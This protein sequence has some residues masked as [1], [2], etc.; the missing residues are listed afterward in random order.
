M[1]NLNSI[2]LIGII[3]FFTLM[4]CI[5]SESHLII[6]D[7]STISQTNCEETVISKYQIN[8]DEEILIHECFING[9]VSVVNYEI[10]QQIGN[11]GIT[12]NLHKGLSILDNSIELDYFNYNYFLISNDENNSVT[13]LNNSIDPDIGNGFIFIN[14]E[15]NYRTDGDF[16]YW[17]DCGF[18]GEPEGCVTTVAEDNKIRCGLYPG[19]VCDKGCVG[20]VGGGGDFLPGKNGAV[21][22]QLPKSISEIP[23]VI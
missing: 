17:C 3:Y 12:L 9:I 1:R 6:N 2:Q 22:L 20:S 18:Q 19:G 10:R 8:N 15:I 16:I 14:Q 11:S 4:S 7:E 13:I 21:L 23:K 5:N